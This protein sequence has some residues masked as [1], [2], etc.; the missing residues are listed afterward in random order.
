M[1]KNGDNFMRQFDTS[2]IETGDALLVHGTST[3]SKLIRWFTKSQW[4]H[5]GIFLWDDG[6]LYIIESDTIAK[7]TIKAG[8]V[9]TFFDDYLQSD[10]KLK[11]RR[12]I[13]IIDEE[14]L[15]MICMQCIGRKRYD[16]FGTFLYQPILQIFHKWLGRSKKTASNRFYCSE[17]LAF[18][19]NQLNN[20]CFKN[21]NKCTPKDIDDE[22][23]Y[24]EDLFIIES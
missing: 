24:L 8:V 16:Y 12:P 19:Y 15:H 22:K 9:A 13:F 17:F 10:K 20:N 7:N 21:W 2:K 1:A 3:L 6:I 14:K 23:V 18:V 5:A 11:I 4:N